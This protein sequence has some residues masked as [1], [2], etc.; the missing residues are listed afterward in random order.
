MNTI[1][2]STIPEKYKWVATD[3]DRNHRGKW[4]VSISGSHYIV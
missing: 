1:D 4:D 2:W 3:K